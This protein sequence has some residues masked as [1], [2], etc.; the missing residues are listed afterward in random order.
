MAELDTEIKAP[1]FT[2][3]LRGYD[4]AQ[5]DEYVAYAQRLIADT[6]ARLRDAETEYVFDQHAAI[7]PRIAEIFALAE[8]EARELREHVTTE[9]TELVTEARVEAKAIIDAAEREARETRERT[10]RDHAE[11]LAEFERDRDRLREEAVALEWRKSE[12]VGE[13][14]RL[15]A[16]LGEAAGLMGDDAT[17]ITKVLPRADDATIELPAISA[18]AEDC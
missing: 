6:E 12:A 15:R 16:A 1:E 13:L 4:R 10:Q 8:T 9:A 5:V 14:N 18:D 17:A 3:T 7:G 2:I 11:M